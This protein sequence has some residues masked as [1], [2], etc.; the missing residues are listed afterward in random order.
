MLRAWVVFVAAAWRSPRR[1]EARV[2]SAYGGSVTTES[3][4]SSGMR[5]KTWRQS[6][7]VIRIGRRSG[8]VVTRPIS[9]RF[10]V[11][12]P[13]RGS[14]PRRCWIQRRQLNQSV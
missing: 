13:G 14:G 6:P 9:A 5:R 8:G 7:M 11:T 3:M 10:F 1:A 4:D 12:G 2:S